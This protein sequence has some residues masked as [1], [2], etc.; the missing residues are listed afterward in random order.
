MLLQPLPIP[1]QQHRMAPQQQPGLAQSVTEE[2]DDEH[3][4]D[5]HTALVEEVRNTG[6]AG[7]RVALSYLLRYET[8]VRQ[9]E[10]E[11]MATLA[12]LRP[13]LER[14]QVLAAG[15]GN[16]TN[17]MPP[18]VGDDYATL[19]KEISYR[20]LKS[21][22]ET[23]QHS[24]E[25]MT[26]DRQLMMMLRV[27]T[28]KTTTD[29]T[30]SWG[31]LVMM[32]KIC[33]LGMLTLQH[34]PA[35]SLSRNRAR[36]RTLAMLSLF[37]P[38]STKLF[39]EGVT[40]DM[41]AMHASNRGLAI[42]LN[43]SI[44]KSRHVAL[45]VVVA[46]VSGACG[47]FLP[48]ELVVNGLADVVQTVAVSFG[49]NHTV[50]F[51]PFA[52]KAIKKHPGSKHEVSVNSDAHKSSPRDVSS[53]SS[54]TDAPEPSPLMD[55]FSSASHHSAPMEPSVQHSPPPT[56]PHFQ[57]RTLPLHPRATP[58]KSLPVARLDVDGPMRATSA[59]QPQPASYVEVQQ[60]PA[61]LGVVVGAVS[62][63]AVPSVISAVQ[64]MMVALQAS[65]SISVVGLWTVTTLVVVSAT[66]KTFQ[67]LWTLLTRRNRRW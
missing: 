40:L 45:L 43:K 49:R 18:T 19:G 33:V 29:E 55:F 6:G 52:T 39:N 30:I 57:E 16:E 62:V 25:V 23:L 56:R 63:A 17:M 34:M 44:S 50:K 27:L 65:S 20:Q 10:A 58:L 31:E 32:Y 11:E 7:D 42:D 61:A 51:V 60:L 1:Q 37:E 48:R 54:T 22:L 41:E 21:V 8:M 24:S 64:T 14:I 3:Q 4:L 5:L 66:T 12:H 36:E 53:K 15:N 38:P 2:D 35:S 9:Q 47:A 28:Q 26:T 13:L 67:W 59:P 46:L